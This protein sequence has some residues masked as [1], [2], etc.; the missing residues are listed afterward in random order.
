MSERK[1]TIYYGLRRITSINKKFPVIASEIRKYSSKK[2]GSED[3]VKDQAKHVQSLKQKYLDL[4]DERGNILSAIKRA[5]SET[6]I[7]FKGRKMSLEEAIDWKGI[8]HVNEGV[9]GLERMLWNSFTTETADRETREVRTSLEKAGASA[10]EIIASKFVPELMGW[11]ALDIQEKNETLGEMEEEID[12]LIT[13]AN[14]ETV[15][16]L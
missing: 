6:F 4:L 3:V 14:I 7:T 16:K 12:A 8:K 13:Q 15:L 11:D 10:E 1:L 2:K 5:N 9:K